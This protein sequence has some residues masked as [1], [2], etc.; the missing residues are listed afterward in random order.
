MNTLYVTE[1]GAVVRLSSHSLVV[2]KGKEKLAQMPLIRL[3]A[4]LLF[5]PVQITTQAMEALLEEG[6]EVAFL[7]SNGKLRGRLHALSAKNVFLRLAQYE[8]VLDEEFSLQTAKAIVRAKLRHTEKLLQRYA[9]RIDDEQIGQ[10]LEA[11]GSACRRIERA[12]TIGSLMGVEGGAAAAYFRAFGRLL[13]GDFTFQERSRRPPKDPVNALLSLGYTLVFNELFALAAAHGLDPYL[14]FLHGAVYGR[15]SL[16]LDLE[17][18][19]RA[20]VV[21]RFVLKLINRR[22]LQPQHFT[23]GADGG[24]YLTAE[25]RSLFFS[26]YEKLLRGAAGERTELS[27]R[28][29][30]KRQVRRMASAIKNREPYEPFRWRP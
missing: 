25:G 14:G 3:D 2:C 4:V 18:E 16:A 26:H 9:A 7:T 12:Q 22:I 23:T 17:K 5:G 10:S 28:D 1:P 27:L 20:P 8:R 15:P 6:I 13:R 21:D 11:V 24:V 30:L 29:L 19:F